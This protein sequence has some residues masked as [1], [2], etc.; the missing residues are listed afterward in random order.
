MREER[1]GCHG[2]QIRPMG[3]VTRETDLDLHFDPR[4]FSG[5]KSL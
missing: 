4:H 1:I 3:E 5:V 2:G